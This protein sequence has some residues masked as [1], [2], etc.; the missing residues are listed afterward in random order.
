M[1]TFMFTTLGNNALI[2]SDLQNWISIQSCTVSFIM[3]ALTHLLRV[4]SKMIH[5]TILILF[6]HLVT[7]LF[8]T[9]NLLFIFKIWDFMHCTVSNNSSCFCW[10]LDHVLHRHSQLPVVAL[11][12]LFF[13]LHIALPYK[14]RSFTVSECELSTLVFSS[15]HRCAI[16]LNAL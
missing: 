14:F 8:T 13:L 2:Q 15:I 7:M 1:V 16:D 6:T 5:L 10:Q 12:F 11:M 9:L 3:L 4:C